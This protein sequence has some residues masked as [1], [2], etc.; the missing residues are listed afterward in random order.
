MRRLRILVDRHHADL[1]Y[2]LQRLFEDRLGFDLYIPVG[3]EWWDEGIWQFGAVFGDD[4]LAQQY[5]VTNDS[6]HE[7]GPGT[8]VWRDPAH[9]HR[10]VNCLT[11]DAFRALGDFDFVLASVQENAPGFLRLAYEVGAQLLYHVGNTGQF[12]DWAWDALVISTSEMPYPEGRGVTI[13]QEIDSGPGDTFD[14]WPLESG[15][16]VRNFVNAFDR[17]PGYNLFLDAE[18]RM[19]DLDVW[20]FTVHGHDGRDGDIQPI[21]AVAKLMRTA[22][23]GWHDKPVGDGFG[24]VI[25]AW[26]AIG[27]PLIGHASYYTGE[28]HSRPPKMAAPFWRDGETCIDLDRHGPEETVALMLEIASD[29]ARH[30]AMGRALR[31][32]FDSLVDYRAEAEAVARLLG[33]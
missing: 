4:R 24:H 6:Y 17:L 1:L 22:G 3:H 28:G 16:V 10:P 9:P 7:V 12:I 27:R 33:I 21:S 29:R 2:A 20:E 26:A 13:H 19:R 31:A 23:F 5:L 30:E 18:E 8:Y 15:H 14:F 11:L 32:T 25:H